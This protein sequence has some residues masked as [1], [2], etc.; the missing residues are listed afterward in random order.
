MRPF[1]LKRPICCLYII[2]ATERCMKKQNAKTGFLNL[3][4]RAFLSIYRPLFLF[5]LFLIPA[6]FLHWVFWLPA[7]ILILDVRA[8]LSDFIRFRRIAYSPKMATLLEKSWC[9]RGVAQAIWSEAEPDYHAKGYRLYHVLPVGAPMVF[10]KL[11][12]W[13]AVIGTKHPNKDHSHW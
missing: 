10:F 11:R 7:A 1:C 8:R 6:I 13:E 2:G 4:F 12:F 5:S 3:T 9:K